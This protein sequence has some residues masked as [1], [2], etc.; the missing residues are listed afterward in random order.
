MKPGP[1]LELRGLRKTFGGV[2]ANDD[3]SLSVPRG[4]IVGLIGPNGSGKTTLFNG[5]TGQDPPEAG[6]VL[7]DAR[8]LAGLGPAPIARLGLVRTFQQAGI[9]EAM[10]CVQGMQVSASHAGEGF[11]A[12]LQRPGTAVRER[13]LE[14]LEFVGLAGKRDQLAG[15]LSYG[16]RKLLEFAMALMNGPKMLLL[17]EPTAGVSP[18]LIPALVER[19]GRTSTEGGITLLIIE[20]NIRV[21]M[22]LAQ[23]IHCLVRGR[24]LASG[25]PAQIRADARVVDAYLG[26]R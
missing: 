15:E 24:L 25:T 18:A 1:L 5:I 16:Q 19:L 9:F 3:I 21:V 12:L 7:F 11:G 20:H 10:S 23:Q 17:D 6:E 22:E 26:A 2:V 13:A 14:L 4:A 8:S